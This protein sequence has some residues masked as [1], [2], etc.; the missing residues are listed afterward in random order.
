MNNIIISCWGICKYNFADSVSCTWWLLH[1]RSRHIID[2]LLLDLHSIE[3]RL[4]GCMWHVERHCLHACVCA[5]IVNAYTIRT[6]QYAC[7]HIHTHTHTH[8][9]IC[10]HTH[11]HNHTTHI[12]NHTT[13]TQSHNTHTQ[14]HNTH[15]QSHNTHTQSSH[16]HNHTTHIR[17]PH[18]HWCIYTCILSTGGILAGLVSDILQARAFTSTASLYLAIPA[19][20]IECIYTQ[21]L[22]KVV[23]MCNQKP[24]NSLWAF[25]QWTLVLQ[26]V[27]YDGCSIRVVEI[28]KSVCPMFRL[29]SHLISDIL[30]KILLRKGTIVMIILSF[31]STEQTYSIWNYEII[32]WPSDCLKPNV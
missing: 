19:V 9:H 31:Y 3:A 32:S 24:T 1:H 25:K 20:S 28:T 5:L 6:A 26:T 27:W 29:T 4:T 7:M 14:S 8:T 10:T 11:T 16:I 18:T 2:T 12:R 17:I 22:M 13:H 23:C 30:W 15:T 21:N